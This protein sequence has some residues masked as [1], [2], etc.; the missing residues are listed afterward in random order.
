M[1]VWMVRAGK[2]GEN[3]QAAIEKKV[4]TIDWNDL[5]DLSHITNR[6][7]LFSLFAKIF[8]GDSTARISNHVGQVWAFCNRIQKGDLVVL[9]L[10]T[11]SAIAIGRVASDYEYRT[12]LGESIRHVRRVNWLRTDIP[13]TSFDQDLLYSFGAFMTVCQIKRNNAEERINA[14]LNG[15]MATDSQPDLGVTETDQDD[16]ILDI[17]QAASDQIL[18][19]IQRKFAGHNLAKLVDAVLQAEGYLTRVSPAGPDGGVD[20]LAGSGPMGFDAPRL[21]VQVKSS[22]TPADVSVLRELQGIL[23]T[24]QANQGLLVSWGGF[25]PTVLKEARQSFFTIRLWDSGD[26][27]KAIMRNYDRL[28]DEL[29]AEL[30]LKRVWTL[31]LED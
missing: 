25:K 23:P 17:S 13:R 12:D 29:Q 31:V 7:Q 10:K 8:P 2:Y 22:A 6:E 21:C 19:F 20:I 30:P 18:D 24:F 26:L 27:L 9:P 15:S 5:P 14:K 3:E 11:Q 1:S 28:S 16:G 4:V